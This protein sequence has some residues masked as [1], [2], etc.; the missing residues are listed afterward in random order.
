MS[1]PTARLVWHCPYITIYYSDN[2]QV[3]GPGFREFVL[4]RPDGENWESDE[5]AGNRIMVNMNNDFG[6]WDEWKKR[7]KKGMDYTF[8]LKK[9]GNKVTVNTLNLGLQV[10]SITEI[11]D[12]TVDKLYLAITGDQVALTDIRIHRK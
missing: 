11:K 9:E 10:I 6:G 8:S 1:L 4:I 12:D 3:D 5:G 7:N 2:G